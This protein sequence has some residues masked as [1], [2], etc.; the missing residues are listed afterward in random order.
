[1]SSR[2]GYHCGGYFELGPNR[3]FSQNRHSITMPRKAGTYIVC[4][5][6]VLFPKGE[7]HGRSAHSPISRYAFHML[8][9]SARQSLQNGFFFVVY[10]KLLPPRNKKLCFF[11]FSFSFPALLR[12]LLL[13][14]SNIRYSDGDPKKTQCALYQLVAHCKI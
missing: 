3:T 9:E 7:R 6:R 5:I 1:M 11:I 13:I 2:T 12:I 8:R 14:L 4:Q 10:K